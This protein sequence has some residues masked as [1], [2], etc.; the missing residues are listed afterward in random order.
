MIFLAIGILACTLYPPAVIYIASTWAVIYV[1]TF[2]AS[3]ISGL[4]K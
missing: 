1:V 4:S 2:T 3:V